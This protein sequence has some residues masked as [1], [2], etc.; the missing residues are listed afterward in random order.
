MPGKILGTTRRQIIVIVNVNDSGGD[1]GVDCKIKVGSIYTSLDRWYMFSDYF[2]ST[3]PMSK[4]VAL[5]KIDAMQELE[6][7]LDYHRY[8]PY[9]ANEA[10]KA[11]LEGKE[12]DLVTFYSDDD[13]PEE[14]YDR[15]C[16]QVARKLKS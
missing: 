12:S 15:L 8:T 2:T 1:M 11:V 7:A 10:R 14:Y 3:E 6:G 5:S 16:F 4:A 13:V 9:W